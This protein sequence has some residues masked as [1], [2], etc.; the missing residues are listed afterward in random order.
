[1]AT[2]FTPR[3]EDDIVLACVDIIVLKNEKLI[4]SVF[5]KQ[6]NLDDITNRADQAPIEYDILLPANLKTEK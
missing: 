3:D 2:A 4:D 6:R 1:M 5:L